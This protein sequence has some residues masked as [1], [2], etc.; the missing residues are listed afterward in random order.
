M[1]VY[2]GA[3]SLHLASPLSPVDPGRRPAIKLSLHSSSDSLLTQSI[4]FARWSNRLISGCDTSSSIHTLIEEAEGVRA[5]VDRYKDKAIERASTDTPF[6]ALFDEIRSFL[7]SVCEVTR[8]CEMV[9]RCVGEATPLSQVEMEVASFQSSASSFINRMCGSG[10]A[11]VSY[12]DVYTPLCSALATLQMGMGVLCQARRLSDFT[13]ASTSQDMGHVLGHLLVVPFH[14]HSDSI[15]HLIHHG[16]QL[17]EG[18]RPHLRGGKVDDAI[19]EVKC[20]LIRASLLRASLD[21]MIGGG[22]VSGA[23]VE[24]TL[25]SVDMGFDAYARAWSAAKDE[26]RKRLDEEVTST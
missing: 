20:R 12:A 4:T 15:N 19:N 2:V 26:E 13:A 16:L 6:S 14:P 22:G 3:L 24:E 8:V 10:S 23:E 17:A 21:L 25:T 18:V 5:M 1:L 11:Y 9:G 7:T